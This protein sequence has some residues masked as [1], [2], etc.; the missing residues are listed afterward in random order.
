MSELQTPLHE[1]ADDIEALVISK[2]PGL[3]VQEVCAAMEMVRVRLIAGAVGDKTEPSAVAERPHLPD[4][5]AWFQTV[6][7]RLAKS[8]SLMT[9]VDI[10]NFLRLVEAMQR[11][12]EAGA[13]ACTY[14]DY[15]QAHDSVEKSVPSLRPD[16]AGD[17]SQ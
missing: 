11:V 15:C 17:A 7:A 9:F 10:N 8:P 13:E 5:S 1:L 2:Y 3:E 14:L 12:V 4:L 6:R 16:G